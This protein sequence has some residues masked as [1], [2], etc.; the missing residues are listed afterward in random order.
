M[1]NNKTASVVLRVGLGLFLLI[2]GLAKFMQKS[3]WTDMYK[4]LYGF[5]TSSFLMIFGI[6]QILIAVALFAGFKTRIAAVIGGVMHL[7]TIIVTIKMLFT[8]FAMPEGM[9]PN[10]LLFSSVPILAA[11]VALILMSE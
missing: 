10:I 9:P 2:W 5:D 3:M 11:F 7:T 4:M 6:I 1:I 8:P